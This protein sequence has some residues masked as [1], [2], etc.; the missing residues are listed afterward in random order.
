MQSRKS[1]RKPVNGNTRRK[2][3]NRDVYQ[4]FMA[5]LLFFATADSIINIYDNG[6]R[7]AVYGGNKAAV[8]VRL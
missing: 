5:E 3:V 2:R 6:I 7:A 1:R 4:I 8:A